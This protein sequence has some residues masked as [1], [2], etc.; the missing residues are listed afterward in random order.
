MSCHHPKATDALAA[1][2]IDDLD[3]MAGLW[4]RRFGK[5]PTNDKERARQVRFLQSRG[6]SLS[7]IFRLLRNPP[8]DADAG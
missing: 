6:F 1:V 7:A 4:R 3:A 8:E 2:E 5:P